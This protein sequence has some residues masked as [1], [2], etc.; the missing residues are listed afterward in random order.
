M[1]S[2]LKKLFGGGGEAASGEDKGSAAEAV[3]YK[4]H[5]IRPAP[6]KAGSQF[7]TAGFIEKTIDGTLKS[8]RFVRVDKHASREDAV[9]LIIIKGHQIIDEQGDRIYDAQ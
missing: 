7:Q 8:Y 9:T 6:M 5:T 4:G 3:E 1:V 2:F